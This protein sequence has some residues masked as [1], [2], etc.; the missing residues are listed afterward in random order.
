[1]EISLLLA[2]KIASLLIICAIGY[3]IVKIKLVKI[4]DSEVLSKI[5]LFICTPC[6]LLS[7]YQIEFTLEKIQGILIAFLLAIITYIVSI[8]LATILGK[9]LKL[10]DIERLC[11]I[12]SNAGFFVIPLVQFVFVSEYVFYTCACTTCVTF[13][14]WTHCKIIIS[15]QKEIIW[16]KILLNP[17]CI[18]IYLGFAIFF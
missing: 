11:V 4:I 2:N 3:L 10:S 6:A 17:N 12:Y 1:M 14:L 5:L 7:A 18:A 15:R 16:R 8:G 9:C 13:L